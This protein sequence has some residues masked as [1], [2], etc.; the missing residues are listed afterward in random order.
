MAIKALLGPL[1][2]RIGRLPGVSGLL[3]TPLVRRSLARLPGAAR[4]SPW[5]RVHP[6][7]IANGTDTS[8]FV[9]VSD[10]QQLRHEAARAQSL[11]YASSQP[12]IIR[13]ALAVVTQID[14]FTFVDLGCGKGRPLLVASEFPFREIIG[15]E[16]S[17][18]L[19]RTARQNADL[20]RQRCSRRSPIR[21]VVADA[22][23]FPLPEGNLVLFLYNPFGEEVIAKIAE[24]V[25]AALTDARRVV[26]VV[27]YNP[28]AGH[29]FDAV[30]LL[31]RH[32]AGT[33]PYAADELGYG[34]DTEDPV[35]V[36]QG[37]AAPAPIDTRAHARIEIIEPRHRVRLVPVCD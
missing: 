20:V 34:P 27:Y 21:V 18:S 3:G 35:V 13:T 2:R 12:S 9:P 22:A 25:S 36:W 19:A 33:L 15:V 1:A 31:R 32:F 7:D 23:Q 10:L 28:V 26:Y 8:G 17:A 11:P 4:V 37:G 14:T 6:F 29:C 30:P 5:D 24:A 16:L